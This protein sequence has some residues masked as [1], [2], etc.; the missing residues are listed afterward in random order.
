MRN[1]AQLLLLGFLVLTAMLLP[2]CRSPDCELS[3]T[4]KTWVDKNENE[5]WDDNEPPLP[6]VKCFLEGTYT[7]GVGEAVSNL[8]GKAHL[9][10]MLA[11]CPKEAVFS[12]YVELPSG[13]RLTTQER[14]PAQSHDEGP[15][16]FGFVPASP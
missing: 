16:L 7:V 3:A 1:P 11:G 12:V 5:I 4:V 10:V 14:L 8:N 6:D 13:Y 2:G 15:F 9:S